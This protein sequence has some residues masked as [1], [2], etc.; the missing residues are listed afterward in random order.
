MLEYSHPIW[1]DGLSSPGSCVEDTPNEESEQNEH[2][3]SL[4]QGEAQEALLE[5]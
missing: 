4:L 5:A 2:S 1:K 3:D